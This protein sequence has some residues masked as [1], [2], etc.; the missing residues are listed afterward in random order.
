MGPLSRRKAAGPLSLA[1]DSPEGGTELQFGAVECRATPAKAGQDEAYFGPEVPVIDVSS[2]YNRLNPAPGE[3]VEKSLLGPDGS[4]GGYVE[5]MD[6]VHESTSSTIQRAHRLQR[7]N[8]ARTA[9]EGCQAHLVSFGP[10]YRDETSR[11]LILRT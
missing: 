5:F 4:S 8:L 2:H 9:R 11:A 7:A 10:T 6:V 1:H 3:V